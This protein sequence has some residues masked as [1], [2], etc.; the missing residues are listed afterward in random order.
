LASLNAASFFGQ[1]AHSGGWHSAREPQNSQPTT[2]MIKLLTLFTALI[3]ASCADLTVGINND[4]LEGSYSSKGGLVIM[5][6][7]PTAIQIIEPA[8]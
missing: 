2:I 1:F 8:K 3:T 5:P 4:I 7:V 6:K